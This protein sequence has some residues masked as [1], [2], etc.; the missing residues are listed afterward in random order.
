MKLYKCPLYTCLCGYETTNQGNACKHKKTSG[1][2][3][4]SV[5][6]MEF[7][8][9][10]DTSKLRSEEDVDIET[11]EMKKEIERLKKECEEIKS[12][13]K[14][15]EAKDAKIARISCKLV[16]ELLGEIDDDADD[17][18]KE[19]LVYYIV[20]KDIQTRGKIGR[21]SNTNVKKLKSRY[22]IFS[23]PMIF[24]WY[25]KDIVGDEKRLKDALKEAGCINR[26]LGLETIHHSE[27]SI[28]IFHDMCN[29]V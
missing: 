2:H 8:L 18:T 7:V 22:S 11:Q 26:E 24:T 12:L 15:C 3:I 25:S 21:T 16:E 19:G 5:K 10:E 17:N 29:G 20:D 9:K 27:K 28:K 4:M 6:T 1:E 14:E 23:N 13:K